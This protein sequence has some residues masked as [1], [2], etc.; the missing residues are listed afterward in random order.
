MAKNL[1]TMC[2]RDRLPVA[3]AYPVDT[4]HG[5]SGYS[6]LQLPDYAARKKP[7]RKPEVIQLP[8]LGL[9]GDH[10]DADAALG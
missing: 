1:G 3:A 9:D 4:W 7:Q 2:H 5:S 8:L 10:T 6:R